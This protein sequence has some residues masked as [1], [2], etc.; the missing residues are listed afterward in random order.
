MTLAGAIVRLGS[1]IE[2]PRIAFEQRS[3]LPDF[4]M[5]RIDNATRID[6]ATLM[7]TM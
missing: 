6:A 7:R 3:D 5:R 1:G 4:L 2:I